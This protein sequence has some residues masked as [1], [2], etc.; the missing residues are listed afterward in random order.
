MPFSAMNTCSDSTGS[1]QDNA[2]PITWKEY[3]G[4]VRTF[5]CLILLITLHRLN[6]TFRPFKKFPALHPHVRAKE[7]GG[8]ILLLSRVMPTSQ[9]EV[10]YLH[11]LLFELK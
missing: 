3:A 5:E 9:T 1:G 7:G 6:H 4:R 10:S 8:D 11:I 2:S